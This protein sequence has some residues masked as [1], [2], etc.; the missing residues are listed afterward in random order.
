MANA[1]TNGAMLQCSFGIAPVPMVVLPLSRVVAGGMPMAN[2][3]DNKPFMNIMPFGMCNSPTNPAVIAARA[4]ALGAPVPG[5]CVP[6][7]VAPW[8]PG[9]PQVMVGGKPALTNSSKC[10]CSWAGVISV[11]TTPAITINV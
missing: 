5:P 10:T 2:I 11:T 7:T 8:A 9:N 3:L 6:V 4:A 1:V